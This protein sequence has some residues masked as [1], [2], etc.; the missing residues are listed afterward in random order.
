MFLKAQAYFDAHQMFV[1]V[2]TDIIQRILARE[3]DIT[4]IQQGAISGNTLSDMAELEALREYYNTTLLK[5]HERHQ[6]SNGK[7][8]ELI[9]SGWHNRSHDEFLRQSRVKQTVVEVE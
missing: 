3:T 9:D 2:A 7:Y 6:D 5:I 8:Y 4:V 1:T